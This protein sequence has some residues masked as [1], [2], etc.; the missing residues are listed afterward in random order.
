MRQTLS[1]VAILAAFLLVF[2]P[3]LVEATPKDY[4]ESDIHLYRDFVDEEGS[5]R[6]WF[7]TTNC[8]PRSLDWVGMFHDTGVEEKGENK[9][10]DYWINAGLYNWKFVCGNKHCSGAYYSKDNF[11]HINWDKLEDGDYKIYLFDNDGYYVKEESETITVRRDGPSTSAPTTSLVPSL[12]PSS[13]PSFAPTTSVAPSISPTSSPT[14]APTTCSDTEGRFLVKFRKTSRWRRCRWAAAWN[15]A[16]RCRFKLKKPHG[17]RVR[18]GKSSFTVTVTLPNETNFVFP[19]TTNP[20]VDPPYPNNSLSI[21]LWIMPNHE[22]YYGAK[23]SAKLY[24]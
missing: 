11:F 4:C 10:R 12:A 6:F 20:H 3:S 24:S 23:Y 14:E 18:D 15:T 7:H 1:F 2:Q 17:Y 9:G 19:L 5:A 13:S 16:R 21:D 22:P 8:Y